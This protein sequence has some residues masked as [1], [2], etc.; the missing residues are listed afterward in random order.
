MKRLWIAI[1]LALSL[2]AASCG[3]DDNDSD[4]AG[5][6][7]STDADADADEE[8][9]EEPEEETA[10]ESDA[11]EDAAPADSGEAVTLRWR[12]RPDNQAEADVYQAISD[13]ITAAGNLTLEYEPG[14][15]DSSAYQDVLKTE[16]ASGTA[17]DVFWIPGTDVADFATRG[18]ILDMRELADAS[19]HS[20]SDFYEGPMFHLTYDP[21]AGAAGGVLWGLPR[22]VSAF[23]MYLNLDLISEAGAEDPRDL[24]ASGDWNW[25]TFSEV[26][27]D[28]T[29]LGDENRGFGADA[30]WG[31]Y[32]YFVN[33]AGGSFF[34][35]DRTECAFDS[36]ES[37]AGLS[38]ANELFSSGNTLAWGESAAEPFLA[39]SL[40]MFMNGRWATPSARELANFNWD[41][42]KLPD[43]PG[44]PSNW[45]FWGAYVVNADTEHPEEAWQLIQELTSAD[46]QT[47]VSELGANIPSRVDQGLIDSFVTFT[48]PDNSQAFIDGITEAPVAE[49]PLWEGNWPAFD[50][51]I[52]PRVNAVISGEETIES[53]ADTACTEAE[54]AA[55]G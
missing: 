39:G 25:T 22:D 3:G 49:G 5:T 29:A 11:D 17:P 54:T 24:A 36:E 38:F 2:V 48:P 53:F 23:A 14:G 4:D 40:G 50:S 33:A 32:G 20:D 10:D 12:T 13:D 55:F 21:D 19:G 52:G 6:D 15:S 45:L 8:E 27:A 30:W 42:V 18:L 7:V 46:A 34:N 9:A 28:V 26:A 51:A 41:V 44:G 47:R 43:G 1:L 35:E 16:L 31:P 37:L